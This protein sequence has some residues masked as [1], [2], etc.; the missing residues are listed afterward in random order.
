[1]LAK[2]RTRLWREFSSPRSMS[3]Q[4][5]MTFT[6][7]ADTALELTG[8]WHDQTLDLESLKFDESK[9][10][11]SFT[12]TEQKQDDSAS[13]KLLQ[14]KALQRCI[15][16][17]RNVACVQVLDAEGEVE[18]YINEVEISPTFLRVKCV[19][20]KVELTGENLEISLDAAPSKET[21]VSL[22]TPIGDITWRRKQNKAQS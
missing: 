19:N 21:E 9:R 18:L 7:T 20:G 2:G 10:Q 13:R 16:T 15:V 4:Q 5:K 22:A 17:L 14:R 11:C 8:R 6:P 1:M 12:V 3:G